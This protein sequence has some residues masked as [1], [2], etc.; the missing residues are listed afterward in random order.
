MSPMMFPFLTGMVPPLIKDKLMNRE[1]PQ[2]IIEEE[3][4]EYVANKIKK[5]CN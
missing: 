1:E 3:T 5:K 2:P 4:R